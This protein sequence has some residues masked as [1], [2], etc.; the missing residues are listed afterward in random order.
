MKWWDWLERCH[1]NPLRRLL[2]WWWFEGGLS[3]SSSLFPQGL[4]WGIAEKDFLSI[5]RVVS[6]VFSFFCW[7]IPSWK[8]P[9]SE[10]LSIR[11]QHSCPNLCLGDLHHQQ[12]ICWILN[13]LFEVLWSG[14]TCLLCRIRHYYI[15]PIIRG[16][17]PVHSKLVAVVFMLISQPAMLA[18]AM[19]T[20]PPWWFCTRSFL[21]MM[22][23]P[24]G[25]TS[26][27]N[28]PG[29]SHA[30]EPTT[31]SGLV[32]VNKSQNDDFV[33]RILWKFTIKT[34][35]VLIFRLLWASG[36]CK[37]LNGDEA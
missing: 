24:G 5:F 36:C 21:A 20:T 3:S 31:M 27:S 33:V 11:T 22:L 34:L 1:L 15:D 25:I 16:L 8:H 13:I 10:L 9:R 12:S 14:C 4:F 17:F 23:Y 30:S 32:S 35:N 37:G 7:S 18:L 28:T 26:L 19:I 2:S 6:L 29:C